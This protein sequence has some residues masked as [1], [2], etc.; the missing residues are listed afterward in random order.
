TQV[1]EDRDLDFD[2][3]LPGLGDGTHSVSGKPVRE[4]NKLCRIIVTNLTS[5][6]PGL[7]VLKNESHCIQVI[8]GFSSNQ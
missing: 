4:A 8:K 6:D 7:T 3:I 1:W 2:E 5:C